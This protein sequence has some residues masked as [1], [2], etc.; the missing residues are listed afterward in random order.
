[1][2]A[3]R[4]PNRGPSAAAENRAA[5][6]AAAREVFADAGYDAP[7]SLV[8]RRAGVGQGSLYRH[9]PDR[10]SLAL[11]VFEDSVNDLEALA[12]EPGTTL[13]DLLALIT[14]QTIASTAFIDMVSMAPIDPRIRDV[15]A[16]VETL[17]VAPLSRAQRAGG[18]RSDLTSGDLLLAVGM[19]AGILARTPAPARRRTAERAWGLIREG[20]TAAGRAG[21][22][23]SRTG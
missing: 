2:P 14:E 13:T 23:P 15:H 7:L 11:A 19:L 8:A 5:L 17:L 12:A 10:V 6:I 9:F 21:G 1:M 18:I 4:R 22:E 20:M 16:R 3:T